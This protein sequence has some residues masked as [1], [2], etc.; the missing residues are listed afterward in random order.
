GP[1]CSACAVSS[2]TDR[3]SP[4]PMT[5]DGRVEFASTVGEPLLARNNGW[6]EARAIRNSGA[7]Q[8]RIMPA[9]LA[10]IIDQRS[11]RLLALRYLAC[12]RTLRIGA[13]SGGI[14]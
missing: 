10:V 8:L 1:A 4:S 7:V 12:W 2:D 11:F 3:T 6:R 9:K 5:S 14:G 13:G